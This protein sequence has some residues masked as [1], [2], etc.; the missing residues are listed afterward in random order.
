LKIK[1][2]DDKRMVIHTRKKH[3]EPR[4]KGSTIRITGNKGGRRRTIHREDTE[5]K[6]MLRRYRTAIKES[7]Q[8]IKTKTSSIRVAGAAGAQ[9][10]LSRME[11]GEE[12]GAAAGIAYVASRP[13]AG[14]ASKGADLFKRRTA[15]QKKKRI[16]KV[17]TPV[18]KD[19]A[20][21]A[22]GRA[23]TAAKAGRVKASGDKLDAQRNSHTRKIQFFFDKMKAEGEQQ[24][25]LAKLAKDLFVN[26][27]AV[28]AKQ[29]M[30]A[31]G[32]FL[33]LSVLL[34][35]MV[36]LSVV[37]VIAALYNSPFSFFLPALE[38]GDTV[39]TVTSAYISEFNEKIN[40]LANDHRG[41]D[42]G[43]IVYVDF[44]GE[45]TG[46]FNDIVTIYMVRYG[47]GDTATI[48]N[49]TSKSRLKAVFDDMCSYT[50]DTGSEVV[51]N[52]DGTTQAQTVFYVNVT[53]KT[54]YDMMEEYHFD[55]D[56]IELVEEM[57][58]MFGSTSSVTSQSSLTQAEIDSILQDITDSRQKSAVSFAL[59]KVGYPYSQQYR[60]SGNYFDCS[61]LTYYSWKAAGID[62]RYGG[63]NTAAA[64]AEGLE[65]AGR[66]VSYS[67]M[68][69]GD[70][71]FYSYAQ[72]GRYRNISHVA[73]YVGNGMV[74]EAK[75]TAY[76][77]TYN[78]V[79]NPGKIV[80]IGR[81]E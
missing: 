14:T 70:L 12:I 8:S 47:V 76:G 28:P 68:Q 31:T 24:D 49:E 59:T 20:G 22:V 57:M 37:V 38:A 56:Q 74:V 62:I 5:K 42:S 64:E 3:R 40:K 45:S 52:E 13:A 32:S 69:P 60:D 6:R 2:V 34:A 18:S 51:E 66:T 9:A 75:G 73:L 46:N 21:K 61:S 72:N 44:E 63:A 67:E 10:A 65:R 71:I 19:N 48:M 53:L 29:M 54:C 80:L 39:T 78:K 43:Q 77:V 41:C 16:R 15:A 50:T 11:G 26:R 58:Q 17:D 30:T 79:P 36:V 33:M 1:R 4:L 23:K 35:A 81:P 27:M 55:A 25:S 7:R